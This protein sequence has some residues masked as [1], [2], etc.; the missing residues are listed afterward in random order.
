M[1]SSIWFYIILG[2]SALLSVSGYLN[3]Q[4]IGDVAVLKASH[5]Q[6]VQTVLQAQKDVETRDLSCKIDAQ[7]GIEITAEQTEVRTKIDDLVGK[8]SKLKTG[9]VKTTVP[10]AE[11]LSN[12]SESNVLYG[13][14]LLSLDLRLLLNQAYCLASPEDNS[15]C[16][17]TG[18]SPSFPVQSNTGR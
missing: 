10:A 1:F 12:A 11:V 6:D 18:Q 7:S 14:E 8:I 3:Y 4:Y 9:V 17:T 15:V 5:E 13:P 2:L 16:G